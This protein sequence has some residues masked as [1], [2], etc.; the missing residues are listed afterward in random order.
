MNLL[1][2]RT[3]SFMKHKL[4]LLFMLISVY[5]FSIDK[6]TVELDLLP[7]IEGGHYIGLAVG[8]SGF[9]YRIVKTKTS[10]PE[11]VLQSNIDNIDLDVYALIV[12]YY[13]RDDY[14][15]LWIGFGLENWKS[16]IREKNSLIE[17][18]LKQNIATIGAGYVFNIF[19]NFYL[20]PWVA[21]HYDL[22]NKTSLKVGTTDYKI[23]KITPEASLKI[24]YNF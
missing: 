6:L 21:V 23:S 4:I 5:T 10:I 7:Y 17:E 12:D 13:F 18:E 22:G 20:N 11:F 8:N 19:N 24:G 9:N 16:N 14:S 1:N 3:R 2:T 15:G